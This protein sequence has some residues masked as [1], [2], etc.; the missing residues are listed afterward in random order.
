MKDFKHWLIF[1]GFLAL[2]VTVLLLTIN[3]LDR[4]KAPPAPGVLFDGETNTTL[5]YQ[6]L[7]A[8]GSDIHLTTTTD[9]LSS[10]SLED[11]IRDLVRLRF[12]LA[13]R[14]E[15]SRQL[16]LRIKDLITTVSKQEKTAD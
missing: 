14:E 9:A 10:R 3:Y 1:I 13:L 4:P 2:L 16:D 11:T 5:G 7:S 8:A 15:I 6:E 12:E